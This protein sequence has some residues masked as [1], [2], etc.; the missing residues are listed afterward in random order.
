M[1]THEVR[2]EDW[3]WFFDELSRRRLGMQV[4]ITEVD[5]HEA[6]ELEVRSLPL[7]GI[8]Y[9]EKG[10]ARGAIE[11]MA[12]M[13]PDDHVTH[14]IRHP[15]RVYHK[16]AADGVLSSEVNQDEIVEITA[17]EEPPVTYLRFHAGPPHPGE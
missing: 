17:A 10:S 7:M 3:P 1:P 15:K 14:S 11:V 13:T 2:R 8:S 12:G 4:S 9:E 16:T 6:P 5:P